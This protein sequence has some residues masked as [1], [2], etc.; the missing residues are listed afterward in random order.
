MAFFDRLFRKKPPSAPAP[1]PGPDK[2]GAP[3]TV[4]V[5]DDYGRM[6][7][8]PRE[9]WRTEILPATFRKQWNNSSELDKSITVALSDGFI[10]E[11]LDAAKQLHRIAPASHRGAILLGAILL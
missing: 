7:L 10:E 4:K 8:V 11:S 2:P 5:W 6:L 1:E 9:K 3:P